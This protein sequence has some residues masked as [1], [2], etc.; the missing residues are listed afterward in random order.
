MM[1]TVVLCGKKQLQ[2]ETRDCGFVLR[3]MWAHMQ[4][5]VFAAQDWETDETMR[6]QGTA[7]IVTVKSWETFI[8]FL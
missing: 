4:P 8:T 6:I 2:G 5:L 3:Y 1:G 7:S